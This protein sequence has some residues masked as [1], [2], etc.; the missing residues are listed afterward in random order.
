MPV[1]TLT[2]DWIQD[3][4]YSGALKGKLITASPAVNI[5]DIS[6]NIPSFNSAR[7]AFVLKNSFTHFP[8]GS[9]HLI[10]VNAEPGVEESILA[11]EYEGHFFIGNDNGIFGL[12]FRNQPSAVVELP[13]PEKPSG[14]SSLEVF[15]KAASRL[16]N[17]EDISGLGKQRDGFNKSIPRRA[18]IEEDVIN[19]SVIYIDSYQNAITNITRELYERIG[20]GRQFEV[21]LQSNHY[22]LKKINQTYN[23]TSVGELLVL[24]NYLDL[25]EVAI[26]K[27]NAAQLLGL[28][29]NSVIRIRFFNK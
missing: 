21:A 27:G 8:A 11:I 23:E 14:F 19:G 22:K 16:A 1:V 4:Y 7:A 29:M 15:V 17:G 13:F 12:I 24:F 28:D 3:D 10:C 6:S 20:K 5:I 25:L 26:N 9:I 18:T 2:T